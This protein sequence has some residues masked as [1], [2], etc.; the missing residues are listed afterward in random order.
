MELGK[1]MRSLLVRRKESGLSLLA[2]AK[3][4]S[5][6][7]SKL[8]YWDRKFRGIEKNR[9]KVTSSVELMPVHVVADAVPGDGQ[10]PAVLVVWLANGI[11]L[12]IPI[13]FDAVDLRRLVAVLSEC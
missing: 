6:S 3:R 4:E 1:E 5:L 11:S 7:Y 8:Q 2:F 13:G 9:R 12:E 10:K